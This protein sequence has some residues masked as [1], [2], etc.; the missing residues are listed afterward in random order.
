SLV[1]AAFGVARHSGWVAGLAAAGGALLMLLV[2]ASLLQFLLALIDDLLRREWMRYVAAFFFTMTVIGFQLGMR[3]SSRQ[4]AEEAKRAGFSA[5]Q[6]LAAP[7]VPFERIPPAAAPASAAGA[8]PAGWLASPW[9][10]LAVCVVLILVPFVL[11]ARVMATA[12][13]RA[14]VG[15]TVR[16]A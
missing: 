12:A 6:L 4:L 16:A 3:S 5:D 2:T 13:L 7:R 10:G 8:H 15:A 1:A 14:S 11:G 9:V